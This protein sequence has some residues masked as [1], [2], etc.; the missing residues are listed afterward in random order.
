MWSQLHAQVDPKTFMK[1]MEGHNIYGEILT[2]KAT[3]FQDEKSCMHLREKK[4][5]C[6]FPLLA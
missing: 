2:F 4:L 1:K 5:Y 3:N 6:A